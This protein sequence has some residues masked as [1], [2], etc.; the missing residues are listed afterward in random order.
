MFA[1]D[2]IY[3]KKKKGDDKNVMNKTITEIHWSIECYILLGF[4][5]PGT[6]P[7]ITTKIPLDIQLYVAPSPEDRL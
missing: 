6:L 2:N 7:D 1:Y 3:L 4:S 5:L